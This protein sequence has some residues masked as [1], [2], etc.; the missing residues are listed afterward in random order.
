[1]WKLSV[2]LSLYRPDRLLGLQEVQ[3]PKISR[4]S[5]HVGSHYPQDTFLIHTS[6]KRLSRSTAIAWPE[7]LSQWKIPMTTPEIE[8]ITFQL[9]P[10]RT[11]QMLWLWCNKSHPIAVIIRSWTLTA[12]SYSLSIT[13]VAVVSKS[14]NICTI[15]LIKTTNVMQ[16]GAFVSIM[17]VIAL[18]MFRVLFAPIIRSV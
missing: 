5:A 16:H 6:V 18:Y 17:P 1:M 2:K 8:P 15:L 4:Q 11:P 10:H 12:L 3:A 14:I 7:R 13:W 9:L